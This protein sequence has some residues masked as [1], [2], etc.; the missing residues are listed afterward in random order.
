V[1]VSIMAIIKIKVQTF[2]LSSNPFLLF[3]FA[4]FIC[5]FR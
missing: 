3:Q 4:L 1:G 2:P 5:T